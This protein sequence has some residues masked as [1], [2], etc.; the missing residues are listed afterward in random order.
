MT[1]SSQTST[2]TFVGNGVAT[3]F[4]LP[5]RFFNNSD[6]LAYFIDSTTG[7]ATPMSL[8]TDY[9]LI[10]AGEPEVDGSALS[11]LTTTVPLASMRGLYVERVMQ[12]LQQTD[13]VNQGEFFANTHEDVFDRLT[14]LI[15][16]AD[17]NS[18]GAIRV[19]IGDPNTQRLAPAA[20]RANLLLGFDSLGQPITVAPSSGSAADLALALANNTDPL[21]GAAL[22]GFS[23]ETVYSALTRALASDTT[24]IDV[25]SADTVNLTNS[26]PNTR[27]INITGTTGITSFTVASGLCFFV[28]FNAAL[29]LTNNANIVTQSGANI[30]T[31]QGD[32]CILRA[33][34]AN[35]VEVLAYT[36]ARNQ[37]VGYEQTWQDVV[38]SRALNTVYT[39][40]TGKPIQIK[41]SCICSSSAV[42]QIFINGAGSGLPG[43]AGTLPE[44]SAIIPNGATYRALNSSGTAT[45]L[46]WWELR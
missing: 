13:I 39:N 9:T 30:T 28:R 10:G 41:V 17:A 3:A 46:N 5:F 26:A 20:Q 21:K 32:T 31:A 24:R 19:A 40:S 37:A 7:A 11:L 42:M 44:G 2:A 33:T 27:H 16:Q 1:V 35:V 14:M 43:T 6:I 25:P 22:V 38:G 12:Q 34:S 36:P 4:P 45:S 29:T 18:Y 15:Q 8:G 23:S